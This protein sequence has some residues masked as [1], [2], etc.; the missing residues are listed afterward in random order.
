MK[1]QEEFPQEIGKICCS[2]GLKR[3]MIASKKDEQCLST[4]LVGVCKLKSLKN[5]LFIQ[6]RVM[7]FSSYGLRVRGAFPFGSGRKTSAPLHKEQP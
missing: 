2:M 7:I 4:A 6:D 1:F 3:V 5:P